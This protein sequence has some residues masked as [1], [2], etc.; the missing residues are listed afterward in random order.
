[1]RAAKK[2]KIT[3]DEDEEDDYDDDD[4]NDDD[5]ACKCNEIS[6]EL[7]CLLY[8]KTIHKLKIHQGSVFFY[9]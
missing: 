4:I 2:R 1:M 9:L 6:F 7:H 5:S 8:G 3:K